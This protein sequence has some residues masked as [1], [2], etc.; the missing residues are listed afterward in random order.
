M[1]LKFFVCA[2]ITQNKD[3][4]KKI[5]AIIYII[6]KE[7]VKPRTKFSKEDYN[8]DGFFNGDHLDLIESEKEKSAN[9]DMS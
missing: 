5:P 8:K 2:K 1:N 6:P 9:Y 4:K 3:R 7:T